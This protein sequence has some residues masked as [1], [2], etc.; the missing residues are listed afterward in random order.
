MTYYQKFY[1]RHFQQPEGDQRTGIR[2]ATPRGKRGSQPLQLG[3]QGRA[4]SEAAYHR[5]SRLGGL[6]VNL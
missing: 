6:G 1:K 3:R 5:P 2:P 4:P